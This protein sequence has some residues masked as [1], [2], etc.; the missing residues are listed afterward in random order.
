MK[1]I[2]SLKVLIFIFLNSIFLFQDAKPNQ[3]NYIF[4]KE[5]KLPKKTAKELK[6]KNE[7]FFQKKKINPLSIF[8]AFEDSKN[9]LEEKKELL[10]E[11]DEQIENQNSFMAKGNVIIKFNGA[12][13]K[14]DF[15]KYSKIEN[16][17]ISEGNISYQKNNQF[18]EADAFFYDLNK[19]KGSIKNVY[20]LLDLITLTED[21]N[22]ESSNIS[23]KQ[24]IPSRIA[25]AK[26]ESNNIIGL[27]LGKDVTDEDS[28]SK[29]NINNLKKWRF[30]SPKVLVNDQLLS[31]E[32]ASFTNDPFNP[33]Q[34]TLESYNLR[35]ERRNGRLILISP[36][37][38]LN[39]DNKVTVPLARRTIKEEQENL[40]KWGFGFDYED[41]DGFY[42]Y[43]NS[44]EFQI[45]D[46]KY[47]FINEFYLQRI[48]ED[49]TKVFRAKDQSITSEKV[50]NKIDIGD[51]FGLKFLTNS[52]F[53]G[54]EFNTL[55]GLNSLNANR[56]NEAVRHKS[57]LSRELSIN[58]IKNINHNIFF[59]YR[60]KIDTG[61]EG[62]K[63][64][65][66]ALGTNI[67]KKKNF[68]LNNLDLYSSL[69][70]QI[71]NFKSEELDG[72]NLV[73]KNRISTEGFLENRYNIWK[74]NN[75]N[76]FIDESYKY[77]PLLIDQS[78]D[79]VTKLTLTS[80]IYENH[81]SQ[82]I[83]KL[84]L[85]PEVQ[86][87][88]QKKKSF[89][90]TNFKAFIGFF[91]KSGKTPFKFD[92]VNES[93]RIYFE[94]KQQLY[95]PLMFEAKAH[96]NIDKYSSDYNKFVNPTYTLSFNRRAYNF[97]IYT[98]PER[99]I[100]GFNFNIFGIGYEG[101][102]KRFKDK[103]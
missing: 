75:P 95:G 92:N 28:T 82:N 73:S 42:L 5:N 10:I 103:F 58:N 36:W 99:K 84:E 80:S 78:L 54:Y 27:S 7:N 89:D 88:E 100:S 8:L 85:G 68:K 3:P 1:V 17:I 12:T 62:I 50:E 83:I 70:F 45:Y 25:K 13:L 76:S 26:F 102:G 91:E 72:K 71:G 11:A 37:T 43:R 53:L 101:S 39:F 33:A 61:F 30:Q 15:I 21:L 2:F 23:E 34:I 74:K 66:T 29:I 48:L 49:K 31:A 87:G 55:T 16:T 97:E 60:N 19:R 93:E 69:R 67:E 77:T 41:K 47:K 4:N 81:E 44:D 18:L 86:L 90:Y 35:S 46:I 14:T 57:I 40:Q 94:L 64:I 96:L 9:T 22:W 6:R 51:Y 63:E 65:Y 59:T 56:L 20:G 98:I 52:S 79:W 32:R 24:N 38:N